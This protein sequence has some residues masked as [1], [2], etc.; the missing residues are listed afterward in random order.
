MSEIKPEEIPQTRKP[1]RTS[2]YLIGSVL[3]LIIILFLLGLFPRLVIW[4]E[5]NRI[6]YKHDIPSVNV[7]EV[8]ADKNSV[9]LVLP[10]TTNAL[11]FTPIWA[12][13][14]GYLENF[15]V[16][17]GDHVKEGQL[18]AIIDTPEI[19]KQL[20]QARADLLNAISNFEIAKISAK[21][22]SALYEKNPQAVPKQEVDEREATLRSTEALVKAGQANV[23]RLE[24]LQGFKYIIA[25]F[26]GVITERNIDKGS[27]ITAGSAGSPQQ[28]FFLV[29]LDIIR[30]FVNVPQNFYRLI[31]DGQT[32]DVT[33]REFP[34]KVFKGTVART[35]GALDPVARTLLTEVHVDNKDGLLTRG[36]YANVTFRLIPDVAYYIVPFSSVIIVDA[37]PKMAIV[38]DQNKVK[39]VD[40]TLGK[41][42][43]KTIEITSGIKENDKIILNPNEKIK[44][45]ISVTIR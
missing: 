38:D 25:P 42:D 10:S 26:S 2:F 27:L 13:V 1:S 45:G 4:R 7:L 35:A 39:I 36:L 8:K 44:D 5:I 20:L 9:S 11:R 37:G 24:K 33:I 18:L 15:L 30:V 41:D 3:I 40:V 17:I 34:N 43:G 22:W 32:A 23:E 29:K 16:D 14:D 6:A 12:R 21:R 19:D 28:L 31:K